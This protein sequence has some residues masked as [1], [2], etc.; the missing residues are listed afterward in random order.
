MSDTTEETNTPPM[1][2]EVRNLFRAWGKKGGKS[3]SKEGKIKA[4]KAGHAAMIKSVLAK[5]SA[6]QP[7]ASPANPPAA[8]QEPAN[9]QS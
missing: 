9:S 6:N 4:G 7:E 8:A 2:E 3:G 1:T 5:Q